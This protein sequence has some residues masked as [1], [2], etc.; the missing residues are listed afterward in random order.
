MRA[1]PVFVPIAIALAAVALGLGFGLAPPGLQRVVGPLRTFALT[2][3]LAVA[4]T[5]LLPEAFAELG[6]SGVGVF[7]LGLAFPSLTRLV[8][9]F[10]VPRGRSARDGALEF[11]YVGLLVHHVADGMG[12]GAYGG[13]AGHVNLDVLLALAVH[14]VPLVAVVTLAYRA[15]SGVRAACL[16]SAG[17]ALASVVGVVA[18]ASV[19]QEA[20]HHFSAWVAAGVA[21]LLVHVVTHDLERDLPSGTGA[22]LLD[23]AAALLGV[24][25]TVGASAAGHEPHDVA[26]HPGHEPLDLANGVTRLADIVSYLATPLLIG[27]TLAAA[28]EL[29]RR[30]KSRPRLE[31]L[32]LARAIRLREE[33][34]LAAGAGFKA[35]FLALLAASAIGLDALALGVWLAGIGLEIVRA[36]LVLALGLL[37]VTL[38]GGARAG[39]L[40]VE[41]GAPDRF[42]RVFAELVARTSPW[43]VTS[44][45]LAAMLDATLEANALAQA[46]SPMILAL[47]VVALAL[48]VQ[49]DAVAAAPVLAVLVSKGM[50]APVAVAAWVVVA[51]PGERGLLAVARTRGH[52]S[53][54][55]ALIATAG[56]GFAS[57]LVVSALPFSWS[58]LRLPP[59]L[60]R[61]GQVSALVL[62]IPVFYAIWKDGLRGW[63]SPVFLHDHEHGHEHGH[64]PDHHHHAHDH[65]R[66]HGREAA[67]G[68]EH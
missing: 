49:V 51:A 23:L 52:R 57:L 58:P 32:S 16:R 40:E 27:L 13:A 39:S 46:A 21:G 34:A 44:V 37:G 64:P 25:V 38:F 9:S 7:A 67:H 56:I 30:G 41:S 2:A 50:P 65:A 3:A 12:L 61:V 29:T 42:A 24:I 63:L 33:P 53:V 55:V 66:V 59:A 15:Q 31:A 28:F 1:D 6:P 14:T 11:G 54:I 5:H 48:P 47:I 68:H 17:L 8:R 19:S 20:S 22:R 60:E 35:G 10:L 18:S 26:S 45:V 4:G 62:A 43:L 36:L